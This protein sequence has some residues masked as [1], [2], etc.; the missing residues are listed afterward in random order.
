V[1]HPHLVKIFTSGSDGD[2]WFYAM[3]LIEGATLAS[4]CEQLQTRGTEVEFD[5]STWQETVTAASEVARRA[6]LPL[7]PA[8][9]GPTAGQ[10]QTHKETLQPHSPAGH[11]PVTA[12]AGSRAYVRHLVELV[13][14][15]A[16]AAQS[17]HERGIIHRDIKPGNIMVSADG[18]SACLMDLGLA[19]LADEV[20]GRLTKTRQFV[21]TLRY[22]SPE[23]VLAVGR[24][25]PASDVYSLGATLWE[26]LTLR[27]LYGAVEG[28]PDVE[29]MRRI[30]FEE[31]GRLRQ[32]APGIPRDLEAIVG[33]CLQKDS[34][35][36]YPTA[37]EFARDLQRFLDGKPV[38]ARP[39]GRLER[40]WKWVKRRPTT[41]AVSILLPLAVVSVLAGGVWYLLAQEEREQAARMRELRDTAL[42]NEEEAHKQRAVAVKLRDVALSNE[43]EA[44]K[45]RKLAE[46]KEKEAE[47]S[48]RDATAAAAKATEAAAEAK[49][50]HERAEQERER[51]QRERERAER[52]QYAADMNLAQ[53]AFKENRLFRMRELLLRHKDARDLKGFE[54]D[55]LWKLCTEKLVVGPWH[56][57]TV[58]A[59]GVSP[60]GTRAVSGGDGGEVKLWDTATGRS[61]VP[62]AGHP[63]TVHAV[64]F[65]PDGKSFATAGV[66]E[67]V[68]VWDVATGRERFRVPGAEGSLYSIAFSRDG[69]WLAVAGNDRSILLCDPA[70]GRVRRRL[71][72]FDKAAPMEG[73]TRATSTASPSARTVSGWRPPAG[74]RP[75]SFG[76]WP[77]AGRSGR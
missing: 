46:Q 59:V 31:P 5:L 43:Q 4:V 48:A 50:Q 40:S 49:R 41:A 74:T 47:Q 7:T 8:R 68:R 26:L 65:H 64:A 34:R 11:G 30:Q 57:R 27:P 18:S 25:G 60:D 14:Q 56:A 20:E 19:Q 72:A 75:S 21:G 71:P 51:A 32:H 77:K 24:L 29:L 15:V 76:T 37:S 10:I 3:E 36:R 55:Y 67:F 63:K 73:A 2:Q 53:Q 45:Q 23:Q 12:G 28:T 69:L 58:R 54:W 70:S 52:F 9:P 62:V 35:R 61:L 17:L 38:L 13:K 22:A 1:E 39:V 6:E 44:E 16:G 42:A 66:D 33:R